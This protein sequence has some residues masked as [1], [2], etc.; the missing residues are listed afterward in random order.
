MG[1]SGRTARRRNSLTNRNLPPNAAVVGSSSPAFEARIA[2]G[3][4]VRAAEGA[5]EEGCWSSAAPP[6]GAGGAAEV[7]ADDEEGGGAAAPPSSD[8]EEGGRGRWRRIQACASSC[9]RWSAA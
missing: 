9:R 6:R 5:E 4:P 1:G 3:E 7:R 2:A 8:D